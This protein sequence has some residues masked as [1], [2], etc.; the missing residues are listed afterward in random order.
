MGTLSSTNRKPDSPRARPGHQAVSIRMDC[1]TCFF[2]K[3]EVYGEQNAG[4]VA[5]ARSSKKLNF[6]SILNI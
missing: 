1:E 5:W 4:L 2:F 6:S 3:C